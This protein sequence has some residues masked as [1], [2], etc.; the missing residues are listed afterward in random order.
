M[1]QKRAVHKR[2]GT[3]IA[4]NGEAFVLRRKCRMKVV[5]SEERK[6]ILRACH[7]RRTHVVHIL[8]T[9]RT[10]TMTMPMF[11]SIIKCMSTHAQACAQTVLYILFF[12]EIMKLLKTT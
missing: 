2:A 11:I 9:M 8:G 4:E 12:L 10:T 5:P 7:A 3:L 6:R 1:D